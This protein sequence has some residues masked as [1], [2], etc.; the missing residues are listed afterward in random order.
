MLHSSGRK[1]EDEPAATIKVSWMDTSNTVVSVVA[2]LVL[3]WMIMMGCQFTAEE[4]TG[5]RKHPAGRGQFAFMFGSVTLIFGLIYSII[6]LATVIELLFDWVNR[7]EQQDIEAGYNKGEETTISEV[8]K[9]T[10]ATA[11]SMLILSWDI[12]SGFKLVNR[13]QGDAKYNP[14][15]SLLGV[16]SISF[17]FINFIIAIVT[18][19]EFVLCF[20]YS[21]GQ[22]AMESDMDEGNNTSGNF[23]M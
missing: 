5:I 9:R 2:M 10:I 4:R 22:Q 3:I 1:M 18:I 17:G 7:L 19:A 23:I 20:T 15:A 21:R 13:Y 6:G 12:Y 14:L 11:I 16:T 8:L